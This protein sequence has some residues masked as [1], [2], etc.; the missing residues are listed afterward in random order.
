MDWRGNVL[1]KQLEQEKS[2]RISFAMRAQ[3]WPLPWLLVAVISLVISAPAWAQ[4]TAGSSN[5]QDES[6]QEEQQESQDADQQEDVPPVE[7]EDPTK[8][9][10]S[11]EDVAAKEVP[12]MERPPFDRLYFN[13]SNKNEDNEDWVLDVDRL[14]VD[15]IDINR[16]IDPE[17]F[18]G[19]LI[20]TISELYP[21]RK[22]ATPWTSL[23]RVERYTDIVLAEAERALREREYGVAFQTL[24]FLQEQDIGKRA[25]I[26][27]MIDECLYEDGEQ[28]LANQNY[29]EALSIFEELY[30]RSPQYKVRGAENLL[31]K[32]TACINAFIEDKVMTGDFESARILLSGLRD[33]YGSNVD[34][35]IDFWEQD[36]RL[37]AIKRLRDVRA[38]VDAG[39]GMSAHRGVREVLYTMPTMRQS[40][41]GF[42]AVVNQFP[43]VFVGV[44]QP[45][46]TTDVRRI[47]DWSARRIG[48]LVDRWIMEY[49]KPTDE[50]GDY[51][52]PGGRFSAVDNQGQGTK[53]R[54]T[55]N[56]NRDGLPPMESYELASRLDSLAT[57]GS[58]E[59][60]VPWAR[61]VKTIEIENE[62]SIAFTLKNP[63]VRPDSLLVMPWFLESDPRSAE[64]FG[65]YKPIEAEESQT[66]FEFNDRYEKK[67]EFQYPRVVEQVFRNSSEATKALL[68]GDLDVVDRIYPGDIQ[69]LR[70]NPQISVQPYL[71]PSVHML[72]PNPRN[73]F[74]KSDHFRRALHF[75][76]NRPLIIK[77]VIAGGRTIDGFQVSSG[78]FP[79]GSDTADDLSYAYNRQVKPRK[80]SQ[81]LALVLAQQYIQQE[82]TRLENDGQQNPQLKL[83]TLVLAHPDTETIRAACKTIKQ[84]W[85]AIGVQTELKALPPGITVPEDDDY[86]MLYI[87]CQIQEPL[88]DSYRLFGRDG[89]AKLVDPTIEQALR[90]LDY[91]YTWRDITKALNS[92]HRQSANNLTILPLWQVVEH[93]AYRRNVFNIGS[94]NIHLYENIEEWRIDGVAL[95]DPEEEE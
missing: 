69:R 6:A 83:P 30:K 61:L 72:L 54:L 7:E 78:P 87:E 67:P 15:D 36:M 24:V 21:G 77:E 66:I 60:F 63:H 28:N 85:K 41:N 59:Y 23:V 2:M 88:I 34:D 13:D 80:Y 17:K 14:E 62:N 9:F 76:I 50:G 37:R 73:D 53:F 95:P 32:I 55:L 25:L 44:T 48:Y 68:K 12:L 56:Q 19:R 40:I 27:Q 49:Q 64:Y 43:F 90:N 47:E 29:G 79:P 45:A 71:I 42:N 74:V 89:L 57:I 94:N 39:R 70:D 52:F 4:E 3:T 46:V 8:P 92:V 20:F 65:A 84:Q 82:T 81:L 22:F 86:D 58:D 91:A 33:Q 51:L 38:D 11:Q 26:K 10:A 5:E 18:E 31:G 93:Y 16:P 75:A 1:G 35:V